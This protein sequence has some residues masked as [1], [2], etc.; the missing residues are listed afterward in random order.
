[1]ANNIIQITFSDSEMKHLK[2]HAEEVGLTV[3]LYIKTKVLAD[4]DFKKYFDELKARVI[5]IRP[6]TKFN[7]KL[8]FGIDWGNV[9]KGVRLALGKAFY[10][11]VKSSAVSNIKILDK[12]SAHTQ[13]YELIEGDEAHD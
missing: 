11:Y 5:K 1:M 3:P 13:W 6:G 2:K 8:V 9:P 12:D 7:I 10:T 4:T